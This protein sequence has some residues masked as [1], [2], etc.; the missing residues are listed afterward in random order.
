M[1]HWICLTCGTQ[2]AAS[3]QPPAHCPSCEDE[4]GPFTYRGPAWTTLEQMRQAGYHNTI[5]E[6][7]PG[8]L[9]IGIEPAFG[10]TQRAL[11]VRTPQGNVLWDCISYLDDETR[12]AVKR[13]GGIQAIAISHPHYYASM[14]EWAHNFNAPIYLHE[15]DREW[16]MRP[17]K[18]I[19]FWSGETLVLMPGIELIRLGGHFPGGSVLHWK[20]AADGKGV[21]LAGDIISVVPNRPKVSFMYSYTTGLPLPASEVRRI[22]DTIG[23]YEFER[24]YSAWSRREILNDASRVVHSSAERYLSILEH[25]PGTD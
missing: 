7:E 20:H 18:S 17:D 14:V 22:R 8:L 25:F 5:Q 3:E 11:L 23:A 2:Y 21:L 4:R 24:I 15:A 13:L 16:V 19:K 12:E 1:E 9:G 6:H 10:I